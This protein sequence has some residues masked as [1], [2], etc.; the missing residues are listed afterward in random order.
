MTMT[1]NDLVWHHQGP[2]HKDFMGNKSPRERHNGR[3]SHLE[4]GNKKYKIVQLTNEAN[5]VLGGDPFYREPY[6]VY[7]RPGSG[8]R[9]KRLICY[10]EPDRLDAFLELVT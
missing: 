10:V 6:L 9:F 3:W 8:D 5:R 4:T 2:W 1:I 7:G